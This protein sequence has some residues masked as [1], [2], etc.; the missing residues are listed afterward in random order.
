MAA[1]AKVF[2]FIDD[3]QFQ[4]TPPLPLS[5]LVIRSESSRPCT[6]PG[7]TWRGG[8]QVPW[9]PERSSPGPKRPAQ[10]STPRSLRGLPR[11]APRGEGGSRERSFYTSCDLSISQRQGAREEGEREAGGTRAVARLL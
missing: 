2:F 1:A 6:S 7:C 10:K 4:L 8:Q 3:P 5:L 9:E 11:T